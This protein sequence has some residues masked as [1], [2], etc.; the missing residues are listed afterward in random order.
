MTKTPCAAWGIRSKAR[1]DPRFYPAVP[2]RGRRTGWRSQRTGR[3]SSMSPSRLPCSSCLGIL[4]LVG[5]FGSLPLICFGLGIF[6]SLAGDVFLMVSYVRFSDRWFLPGLVAFLLA[7]RGLHRRPE[8]AFAGCLPHL[9]AGTGGHPGA[10]ARRASCG[11]S[12]P[13]CARKACRGWCARSE[14]TG[15]SSP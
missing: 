6:F 10:D 3:R 12:L 15:W 4:A 5:G 14:C 7:H 1:N 2:G 13:G 11:V 9:V 8:Y